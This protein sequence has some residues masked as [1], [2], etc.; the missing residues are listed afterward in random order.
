MIKR[1]KRLGLEL[2]SIGD[3]RQINR[4]DLAWA[5]GLFEGEGSFTFARRG[6][7]V[8]IVAELGMT[9]EDRVKRFQEVLGIGN[10]TV[11][12]KPIKTHWK[13]MYLWKTGS[14]EGVQAVISMLWPWLGPR[15]RNRAKEIL[16]L[17]HQ[18]KNTK[19]LI[20][21][22]PEEVQ[23]VRDLLALGKSNRQTASLIG[24][25]VGFVKHIK[26]GRTHAQAVE[27]APLCQI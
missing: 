2:Q 22:R 20:L 4:E 7:Y 13:T 3:K 15:R 25:S 16:A 26:Q 1:V 19:R 10:T 12:T 6:K 9:D 18:D 11:H 24:R 8:S 14:F 23:K 21:A 17:W 27:V 5:A